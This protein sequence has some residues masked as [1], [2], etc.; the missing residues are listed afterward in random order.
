[1]LTALSTAVTFLLSTSGGV[2]EIRGSWSAPVDGLRLRVVEVFGPSEHSLFVDL[3]NLNA[4]PLV[5]VSELQK[6]I[7][8]AHWGVSLEA[9]RIDGTAQFGGSCGSWALGRLVIAAAATHRLKC[10]FSWEQIG[11][12]DARIAP[13]DRDRPLRLS[14]HLMARQPAWARL[15]WW[16]REWLGDANS[17]RLS[18]HFVHQE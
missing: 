10:S 16:E 2:T 6:G 3:E 8:T 17:P 18:T 15:G 9:S 13:A 4:A 11:Y 7:E 1:M 12:G 5:F 14:A